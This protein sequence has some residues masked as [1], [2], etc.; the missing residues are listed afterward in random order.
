[1]ASLCRSQRWKW[2]PQI[3]PFP[4]WGSAQAIVA[5]GRDSRAPR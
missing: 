1:M 4:A 3:E 5:S 2:Q